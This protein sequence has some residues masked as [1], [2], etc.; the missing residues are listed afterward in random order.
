MSLES[1]NIRRVDLLDDFDVGAGA[2]GLSESV[3]LGLLLSEAALE[4]ADQSSE[5]LVLLGRGI[6][7]A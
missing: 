1:W 3:S 7:S 4:V 6:D 2:G 5:S